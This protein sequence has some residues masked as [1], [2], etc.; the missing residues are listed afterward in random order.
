MKRVQVQLDGVRLE[1]RGDE[2]LL[3]ACRRNAVAVPFSCLGGVCHTCLLR[4]VKGE[5]PA[6]SQRGLPR[7]L[8]SKHYLLACQCHPD[9]PL[10]L[11]RPL[12][13]DRTTVCMLHDAS[14]AG[15]YILL[16]FETEQALACRAGQRLTVTVGP[17]SMLLAEITRC[18][19][20]SFLVECLLPVTDGQVLPD[21]LLASELGHRFEVAGPLDALDAPGAGP[22]ESSSP[23]PDPAL[24]HE[25]GDGLRVRAV[26][27]DFY[28]RVYRDDR[29][30][31][32][33]HNVTL[34]RAIDKQYSFL[35]QLMTGERVYFGDRPR[36]AHHWMV[37]SEELFDYR[38]ALMQNRL[39]AHGLSDAQI[40][41]WTRL[42][43]HYRSDIVKNA[44][45]PRR[46]GG[47]DLPL[48]GYAVQV[49]D[50]GTMCDHCGDAVDA[51]TEVTYHLRLGLV[52][53]G[54]C[55]GTNA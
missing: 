33:F 36:N 26:L 25:L 8:R 41:R 27:E 17:G 45:C 31:P 32:F 55:T 13:A 34:S 48:D 20:E 46:V 37:I 19:P 7:D 29:L 42:E 10:E 35:R 14:V 2:S 52:S 39:E 21:W 49:I 44:A 54:A 6:D 3:D 4:C 38:Q 16:R 5:V 50:G 40:A 18:W 15:A 12:G 47:V 1:V 30:A 22:T 23:E 53:C 43:L 51:G 11:A 24:W 28:E 9:G